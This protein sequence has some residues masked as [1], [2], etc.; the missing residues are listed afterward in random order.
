MVAERISPGMV[1]GIGHIFSARRPCLEPAI[2]R[3]SAQKASCATGNQRK[4]RRTAVSA[5]GVGTTTKLLL[6]LRALHGAFNTWPLLSQEKIKAAFELSAYGE[7]SLLRVVEKDLVPYFSSLL[8]EE[9]RTALGKHCPQNWTAPSGTRNTITYLEDGGA[10]IEIRLQELFGLT[11]G[12]KVNDKPVKLVL[13][14]PNFRPVQITNDLSSFWR[15]GYPE[16]RKELRARYP[17][18]SWPENP[19]TAKPE[20]K[21]RKRG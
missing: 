16:V 3:A 6:R 14:A 10:Q 20:S 13:L 4:P 7:N 8:T 19:L 17:K 21:G 15:S 1:R 11:T 9:H 18:H 2:H 5:L 12:P